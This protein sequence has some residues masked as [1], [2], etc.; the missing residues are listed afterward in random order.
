MKED[1]L[2]CGVGRV[3]GGSCVGEDGGLIY[4]GIELCDEGQSLFKGHS[5]SGVKVLDLLCALL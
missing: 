1:V 4:V 2:G 3:C 5:V